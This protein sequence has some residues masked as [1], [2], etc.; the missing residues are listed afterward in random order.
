MRYGDCSRETQ[1]KS[2]AFKVTR[3]GGQRRHTERVLLETQ[4]QTQAVDCFLEERIKLRQG[5]V[6][7]Y[8]DGKEID[9]AFAYNNRTRW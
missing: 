1:M 8:A 2:T 4:S 5:R 7:L 6:S 9:R 3:W